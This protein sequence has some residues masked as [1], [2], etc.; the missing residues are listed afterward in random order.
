MGFLYN[1]GMKGFLVH[2]CYDQSTFRTLETL[3]IENFAFDLRARSTHL[4]T[5]QS[6]KEILAGS[7]IS[8]AV[9]MFADDS[10]ETI[11]SALDLLKGSGKT[12]QLEFRDKRPAEFYESIGLPYL[13]YFSP[14]GDW[15]KIL[16]S[17][18]CSGIILPLGHRSLYHDLPHLW[19]V[20][21]ERALPIYLH[22]ES[23][24]E[25]SF[26]EGK[27]DILASL[28]LSDEIQTSYRNVDQLRLR[29]MK[30]WRKLNESP[31]RQ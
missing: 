1:S 11:L 17:S 23:F 4:V 13:W 8:R 18:R 2:G 5:F 20:L 12:F 10:K 25:A 16:R 31:A 14:D 19:T 6:L 26:F 22:A 27:D 7:R 21:E 29:T 30:L 3:G 15:E 9:L 28:D 24:E